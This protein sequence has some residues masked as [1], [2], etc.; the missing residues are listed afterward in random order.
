MRVC[1]P[2][3]LRFVG[4]AGPQRLLRLRWHLRRRLAVPDTHTRVIRHKQALSKRHPTPPHTHGIRTHTGTHTRARAHTH[5][6]RGKQDKSTRKTV[7]ESSSGVVG[8]PQNVFCSVGGLRGVRTAR[9]RQSARFR[10]GVA[11]QPASG[12]YSSIAHLRWAPPPDHTHT[13]T[14][15]TRAPQ[16]VLILWRLRR[17]LRRAVWV[18]SWNRGDRT[19]FC[20]CDSLRAKR[21]YASGAPLGSFGAQSCIMVR[22]LLSDPPGG[23]APYCNG[24]HA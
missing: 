15:S 13:H 19:P 1:R 4:P 7:G 5:T 14:H 17:A 2:L 23:G 18:L 8:R 16:G 6:Q 10:R 9:A 24:E 3:H 21:T 22:L 11:G 20:T 12:A